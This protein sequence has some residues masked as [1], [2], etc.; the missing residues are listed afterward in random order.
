M[1]L[2]DDFIIPF[3]IKYQVPDDSPDSVNV[4]LYVTILKIIDYVMDD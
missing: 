3:S 2:D 1:L 4:I